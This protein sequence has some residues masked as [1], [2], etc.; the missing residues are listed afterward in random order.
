MDIENN[1]RILQKYYA[2]LIR[3]ADGSYADG[4]AIRHCRNVV[5][6]DVLH[7]DDGMDTKA[8]LAAMRQLKEMGFSDLFLNGRRHIGIKYGP[9]PLELEIMFTVDEKDRVSSFRLNLYLRYVKHLDTGLGTDRLCGEW[10][11]SGDTLM[12]TVAVDVSK[13]IWGVHK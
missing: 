4:A 11:W 9:V 3:G 10:L 1:L 2:T 12:S 13:I 5:D 6:Q 8:M 7:E